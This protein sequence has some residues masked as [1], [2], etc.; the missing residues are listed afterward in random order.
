MKSCLT[1]PSGV[2]GQSGI[3][4]FEGSGESDNTILPSPAGTGT[5]PMETKK[6]VLL[7]G[8][9]EELELFLARHEH[10]FDR[11][12]R[13]YRFGEFPHLWA[14]STGPGI[15]KRGALRRLIQELKPDVVIHAG[16][17]GVLDERDSLVRGEPL[18]IRRVADPREGKWYGEG[19]KEETVVTLSAP[20]FAP[21][22]KSELAL[23]WDARV[24]DMESAVLYRL[25]EGIPCT[26][27]FCKVAGDLPE[28]APLYRH[29]YLVRG[30]SRKG[31]GQKLLLFLRF[32]GG[33]WRM[34]RLL[35]RKARMMESLTRFMEE[36]LFSLQKGE[37]GAAL[38]PFPFS[39]VPGSGS[40]P[41]KEEKNGWKREFKK[42][43]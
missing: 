25:L 4:H 37:E 35:R 40:P 29:E 18:L 3:A 36:S 12:S 20:L 17:T 26:L 32:P 39:S 27:Y 24:C 21:D 38:P 41:G 43:S 23:R 30:W 2:P 10:T 1:P 42:G 15:K 16:L 34:L 19:G 14:G 6:I 33:P 11:T 13:L 9:K 31:I 22:E 7:T 8:L 5:T 28:D